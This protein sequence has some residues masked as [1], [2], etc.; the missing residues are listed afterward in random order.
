MKKLKFISLLYLILPIIVFYIGYLKL[1][2]SIPLVIGLGYILYKG[3]KE[4]EKIVINKK[5]IR[6]ILL[7]SLLI[8]FTAGLGNMYYQSDDWRWRNAIFRDMINKPWPVYYESMNATLSYYIG[9]WTLP[10]VIAKPFL[11]F[12]QNVAWTIGNL[13]LLLYATIGLTLVLLWI[14]KTFKLKDKKKIILC[15]AIFLLF[16]GLD[17]VG[18][19]ITQNFAVIK[20]SHLE[21][22]ATRYQ[23]SST[24]T[25]LFWVF[26]QTIAT[27]LITWMY[28]NEKKLNNYF[29]L[30]LLALPYSPLPFCGL[31]ILFFATG[32]KYLIEAINN[33]KIKEL[34]KDIF[35]IQNIL[36]LIT[37]LPIYYLFYKTNGATNESGFRLDWVLLQGNGIIHIL[38][39]WTLE[40]GIYYILL[41]KKYKK[42]YLFHVAFLT[43]IFIPIFK[44]G[45]A[46]DFAMRASIPL[47]IV[48]IYFIIDYALHNKLNKIIITIFIIGAITPGC[49]Y[50]RSLKNIIEYKKINCVADDIKTFEDKNIKE[51]SNFVSPEPEDTLFYKYLARDIKGVKNDK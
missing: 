22:W 16:S 19:L 39:F 47:I 6:I 15:L 35:S 13:M 46:A 33:K 14:I 12:G 4:K 32:V 21:W 9:F 5:T 29:L 2:I 51:Y 49:E 45:N 30:I 26:N 11:I 31:M 40:I 24:I 23:F 28:L 38:M 43:L 50:L 44:I 3:F 48:C 1:Y 42:N 34:F 20:A 27:W 37:I 36:A 41:F 8:C 17:F 18:S 10:A 25:L 7:I